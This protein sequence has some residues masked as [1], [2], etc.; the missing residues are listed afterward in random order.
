MREFQPQEVSDVWHASSRVRIV[1]IATEWDQIDTELVVPVS[2]WRTWLLDAPEK[3]K[4]EKAAVDCRTIEIACQAFA[5]QYGGDPTDIRVLAVPDPD[6]KWKPI[7]AGG[8]EALLD[9]W[10]KV[11]RLEFVLVNGRQPQVTTTA[12]DGT[13]ITSPKWA[14]EPK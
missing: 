11:Y 1:G 2:R 3:A 13:V 4:R 6:S 7:L 5:T 8:E 12:P 9:P 14:T 10:G